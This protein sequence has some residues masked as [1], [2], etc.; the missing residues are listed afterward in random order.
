MLP[1]IKLPLKPWF[2]ELGI[3]AGM[4]VLAQVAWLMADHVLRIYMGDSMVFLQAAKE[5][6]T[7]AARSYPYGWA[8]YLFTRPSSS[9]E[10][11]LAFN[12]ACSIFTALAL[13]SW[14]RLF[15]RL[16]LWICLSAAVLISIE[17]AQVFMVRM[18]MA[19]SFGLAA[20]T[21]TFLCLAFYLRSQR[22]LWFILA[23][24]L[25]LGAAALRTNFLPLVLGM[26]LTA[27]ILLLLEPRA[28]SARFRHF[29]AALL[30]LGGL[31]AGYT[32]LYGRSVGQPAGYVAHS[33]MMAIGLVAPLIK[34]EHFEGTDVSGEILG[35]VALPLHDHWQRGNHIWAPDGLW[36]ALSK[37]SAN[38]ELTA[39][40]VT[41]RAMLD[42]PVG[43]LKINIET[44]G[45]YFDARKS[46]WRMLDDIGSIAPDERAIGL[47]HDWFD[48]DV[49]GLSMRESPARKFFQ[50]SGY[51]LVFCLFSLLPLSLASMAIG[52][53]Q[54]ERAQYLLLGF[55]SLGLLACHLLF[56]HIIS[57]RY[58]HP[59]P[60]FVLA[61]VAVILSWFGSML[62]RGRQS[63][64]R[65]AP[66]SPVDLS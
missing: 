47:I 44:L 19:E 57:F 55:T 24:L 28:R 56:V 11:M 41:R 43:L 5:F 39:R 63:S 21:G 37:A 53:R 20:L 64:D 29:A 48:W 3:A 35:T 25:G 36:A 10:A 33:G 4:V 31:H 49:R 8:L 26:S 40:T 46:Y 9:P 13:F 45:G 61:H 58:L 6:S 60:W 22:L 34:P 38:P 54:P 52:W 59:L 50:S 30:V 62:R 27:A 23:A 17:P 14:L 2:S 65:Q 15:L 18:V 32:Q 1:P 51:W 42:D 7:P 66:S 16:S 12:V